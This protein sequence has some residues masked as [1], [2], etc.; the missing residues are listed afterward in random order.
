M[1]CVATS[2]DKLNE[3][4]YEVSNLLELCDVYLPLSLKKQSSI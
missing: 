4:I 3:Y 1:R 2:K